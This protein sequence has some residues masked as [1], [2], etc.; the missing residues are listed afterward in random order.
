M[1]GYKPVRDSGERV[2]SPCG[3]EE[4]NEGPGAGTATK[5]WAKRKF[6]PGPVIDYDEGLDSL[7]DK[8]HPK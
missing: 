2:P 8:K 4:A 1:D 3:T 5:D 7:P 6:T